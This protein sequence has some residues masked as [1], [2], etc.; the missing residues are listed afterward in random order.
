M[1]TV[2]FWP[3]CVGETFGAVGSAASV[4]APATPVVGDVVIPKVLFPEGVPELPFG[5]AAIAAAVPVGVTIAAFEP[6][7]AVGGVMLSG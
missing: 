6:T 4:I 7:P 5:P 3:P 1:P 2:P